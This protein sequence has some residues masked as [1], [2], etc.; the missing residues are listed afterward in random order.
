MAPLVRQRQS[1]HR[2]E[3]PFE[4]RKHRRA[5]PGAAQVDAVGPPQTVKMKTLQSNS[6]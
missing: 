4:E 5:M 6:I 2:S 3:A 1:E